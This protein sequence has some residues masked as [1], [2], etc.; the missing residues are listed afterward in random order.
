MCL[1]KC[2]MKRK[3]IKGPKNVSAVSHLDYINSIVESAILF[4]SYTI[5]NT[6]AKSNNSMMMHSL[7]AISNIGNENELVKLYVEE[8]NN[9]NSN[10]TIKRAY[11]LQNINK[12]P[13]ESK[14]F[15]NNSLASSDQRNNYTISELH[16][17]VKQHD[18][19]F[20]PTE[21]S[22]VVNEDGTPKVVYHGTDK[23]GFYVFDPKMSDDEKFHWF[24]S[25]S[26]VTSNSY[27]QSDNQQLYE[28]YLAIKKTICYRHKR[29]YVE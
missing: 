12:I 2:L 16:A 6:N 19:N 25:D 4:D 23:G 9:I 17:L 28:V 24:F 8:L 27:A 11:Q 22:K 7:Y 20:K 5:P 13:L 3:G 29:T 1:A 15:S 21:A 10:G 26:K 18:K 14:R